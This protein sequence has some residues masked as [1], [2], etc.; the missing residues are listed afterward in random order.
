MRHKHKIAKRNQNAMNQL[1]Q[2]KPSY[3]H[4]EKMNK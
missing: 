2:T 3:S 4:Y 1:F